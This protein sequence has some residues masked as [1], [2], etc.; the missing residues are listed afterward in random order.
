MELGVDLF[1]DLGE[2]GGWGLYAGGGL[3]PMEPVLSEGTTVLE[4]SPFF[5]SGGLS[6]SPR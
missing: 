4:H 2:A 5:G 3:S 6:F 1:F